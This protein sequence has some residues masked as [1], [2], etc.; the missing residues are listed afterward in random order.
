MQT[1][2]ELGFETI[3]RPSLGP[4]QCPKLWLQSVIAVA[5]SEIDSCWKFITRFI[6]Q[7]EKNHG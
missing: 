3:E 7:K 5:D 1:K 2:E 6:H 4:S